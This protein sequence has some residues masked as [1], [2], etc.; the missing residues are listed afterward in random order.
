MAGAVWRC[1][2]APSKPTTRPQSLRG[3]KSSNYL[4][5]V[6]GVH[7]RGQRL[8]FTPLL[9]GLPPLVLAWSDSIQGNK[10][11]LLSLFFFTCSNGCR[12]NGSLCMTSVDFDSSDCGCKC[13]FCCWFRTCAGVAPQAHV[14][15]QIKVVPNS[16]SFPRDQPEHTDGARRWRNGGR[17]SKGLLMKEGRA[18]AW[19]LSSCVHQGQSPY[20]CLTFL[21]VALNRGDVLSQQ[22]T[23]P[24]VA[25]PSRARLQGGKTRFCVKLCSAQRARF[26][27]VSLETSELR[28]YGQRGH[29]SAEI[30][31]SLL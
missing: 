5:S 20:S 11:V 29:G 17:P 14:Y 7:V 6:V 24:S 9:E 10:A 3:R 28:L 19:T 26:K 31:V 18:R 23:E 15:L 27:P 16:F 2:D 8:I 22:H 4:M 30:F 21:H 12:G 13:V 1:C 25:A